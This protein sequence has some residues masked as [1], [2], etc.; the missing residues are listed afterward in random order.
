MK[1][2]T[3]CSFVLIF[4]LGVFSTGYAQET[5][6]PVFEIKTDSGRLKVDPAYFQIL[7]D[8]ANTYT[9]EEV[10]Q[11]SPAFRFETHNDSKPNAHTCWIRMQVKNALPHDLNVYFCDFNASF[12]DLYWLDTNQ[13]WQHQRT[14]E[15]VPK[16]Q[17]PDRNGNKEQNRLFLH[18]QPGQQI[19]L[20]QRSEIAFWFPPLNYLSPSFQTEEDLI[21]SAYKAL[22]IDT[23]WENF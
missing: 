22:R 7:E 2:I 11:L 23:I 8:T 21:H 3:N 1:R 13:R 4:W 9:F 14:G 18:L 20:Y 17:I 6:P 10:R 19:T 5:W 12:M 15:M 16:S